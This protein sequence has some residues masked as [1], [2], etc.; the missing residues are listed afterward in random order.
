MTTRMYD[1]RALNEYLNLRADQLPYLAILAAN[2]LVDQQSVR[3]SEN[4]VVKFHYI[5]NERIRR[6]KFPQIVA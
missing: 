4:L 2:D 6:F 5:Y 3:V 1:R